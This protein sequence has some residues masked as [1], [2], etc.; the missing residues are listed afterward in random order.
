MLPYNNF[1]LMYSQMLSRRGFDGCCRFFRLFGC[2]LEVFF[3]IISPLYHKNTPMT[4]N[5]PITIITQSTEKDKKFIS[6]LQIFNYRTHYT[7]T[8]SSNSYLL[9]MLATEAGETLRRKTSRTQPN[10]LKNQKQP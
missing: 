7:R 8:Q 1:L 2:V 6:Q 4:K 9:K 3:F 10:S 5:T